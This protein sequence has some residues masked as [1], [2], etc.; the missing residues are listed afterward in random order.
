MR[1]SYGYA[2]ISSYAML[3]DR[4]CAALVAADGSIDWLCLPRFDSPSVFARLLD[5]RQGGSFRLAPSSRYAC[6]RRYLPGSLLLE[7]V[8]E[9]ASG[10]LQVDD[11]LDPEGIGAGESLLCRRIRGLAGSV[12]LELDCDP[13]AG[14]GA[15]IPLWHTGE[16]MCAARFGPEAGPLR[17]CTL[18][19]VESPR[20]TVRV[21]A[22]EQIAIALSAAVNYRL[23]LD[24]RHRRALAEWRRWF[25][26]L[27][28]PGLALEHESVSAL[29]LRGLQHGQGGGILAAATTSLPEQV[30]GERNWDYR[31]SWLRDSAL[32]ARVLAGIGAWPEAHAWLNWLERAFRLSDGSPPPILDVDA[33]IVAAGA[34]RILPLLRGWRDSRP[35]RVG[36]AASSQLQH[37]VWGELAAALVAIMMGTPEPEAA[38]LARALLQRSAKLVALRWRQPDQGIWEMRSPPRHF[39]HSKAMGWLALRLASM[40]GEPYGRDTMRDEARRVRREALERGCTNGVFVQSYQSGNVDACALRLA[41]IGII[42]GD[43]SRFRATVKRVERELA[44]GSLVK[45]YRH[46]EVDDGCA[47]SEAAFALCSYWL[48]EALDA[49]GERERALELFHQ[50]ANKA[51]ALG[52]RSE[53]LTVD[54][55]QLGNTPQAFTHA[56]LLDA[57]AMFVN[58]NVRVLGSPTVAR[59][60]G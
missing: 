57:A 47:G 60:S 58:E 44:S 9:T 32:S 24:A 38:L 34:E 1:D 29:V 51:G 19:G 30:G 26:S 22:G 14:Y 56:G 10:R 46:T 42:A 36:N 45:R 35:V 15:A 48:V 55:E 12:E 20:C 6:A 50:I 23:D 28:L 39:L 17:S 8:Y 52:L 13:R 54:G 21:D 41:R 18:V 27:E 31:Y 37:D 4:R 2:P 5:S 11:W 40:L 53:E 3:S 16:G 49:V 33:G 43:D 25:S 59:A 7:T